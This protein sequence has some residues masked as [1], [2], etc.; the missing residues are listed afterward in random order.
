MTAA[1]PSLKSCPQCGSLICGPFRCRFSMRE[2]LQ[3]EPPADLPGDDYWTEKAK[4]RREE[5]LEEDDLNRRRAY[6]DREWEHR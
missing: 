6:P 2:H 4:D 3:P 5:F 1:G